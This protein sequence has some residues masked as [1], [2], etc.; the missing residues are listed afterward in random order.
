MQERINSGEGK[1]RTIFIT[2][3]GIMIPVDERIARRIKTQLDRAGVD[4]SMRN[5]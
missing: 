2:G 3:K 1:E 4:Y 5:A